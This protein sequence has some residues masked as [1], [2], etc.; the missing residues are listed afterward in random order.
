MTNGRTKAARM[1][2]AKQVSGMILKNAKRPEDPSERK[3]QASQLKSNLQLFAKLHR[4][5]RKAL[6]KKIFEQISK[7][8]AGGGEEEGTTPAKK[9]AVLV[10][11]APNQQPPEEEEALEQPWYRSTS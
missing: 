8:Y 10:E 1:K 7:L 9:D 3:A 6:G 5:E 11:E 4:E 2:M